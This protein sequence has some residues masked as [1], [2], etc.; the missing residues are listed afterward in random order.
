[1]NL[2]TV[3]GS[4]QPYVYSVLANPTQVAPCSP[5]NP[6]HVCHLLY[7]FCPHTPYTHTHT[8]IPPTHIPHT[9]THTLPCCTPSAHI[10]F[11]LKGT[12]RARGMQKTSTCKELSARTVHA[13]CV[14]GMQI[15]TSLICSY[16][17]FCA[18]CTEQW[19]FTFKFAE[20]AKLCGHTH[21]HTHTHTT[22]IRTH[23]HTHAYRH[24]PPFLTWPR[25][26]APKKPTFSAT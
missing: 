13:L 3:H 15:T 14:R 18:I 1:V 21:N 5:A 16:A 9:H 22:H 25:Q 23:T 12:Q 6:P 8:H 20:P 17:P 26:P 24:A 11:S 2:P 10:P 4:G 19:H 7:P